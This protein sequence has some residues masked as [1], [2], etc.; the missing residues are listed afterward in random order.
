VPPGAHRTDR[1]AQQ[2][3]HLDDALV[4][5]AQMLMTAIADRPHA[6]LD[7]AVL[8]VDAVDAS[9]GLGLLRRAVDEIGIVAVGLRTKCRLV[10]MLGAVADRALEAVLVAERRR[11]ARV[12]PIVDHRRLV[13][14][15]DPRVP[16]IAQSPTSFDAARIW[17]NG[18]M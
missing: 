10:D 13:I 16:R 12:Y 4:G 7:R 5:G 2:P 8:H 15:R 9:E 14:D 18:R 6:L 1:V 3:P 17:W 11:F